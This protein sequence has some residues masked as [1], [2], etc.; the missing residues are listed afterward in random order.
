MSQA[1]RWKTGCNTERFVSKWFFIEP[2]PQ[3]GGWTG[4][5]L[6]TGLQEVTGSELG[7]K[8]GEG[9]CLG[10]T[11]I[12]FC[13]Q[14]EG[15][16]GAKVQRSGMSKSQGEGLVNTLEPGSLPQVGLGC[17]FGAPLSLHMYT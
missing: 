7:L 13:T 15:L 1:Q 9:G 4:E 14:T 12:T 6:V 11:D 17:C 16:S 3:A 5:P 2:R 10:C 8:A